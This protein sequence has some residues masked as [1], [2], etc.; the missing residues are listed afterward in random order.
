M[1]LH[2]RIKQQS[3]KNGEHMR[4]ETQSQPIYN[5]GSALF[6]GARHRLRSPGTIEL[7]I[8]AWHTFKLL[9]RV[10]LNFGA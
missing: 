9:G 7:L 6:S 1:P 3:V 2:K 10:S 4:D 8:G 5:K